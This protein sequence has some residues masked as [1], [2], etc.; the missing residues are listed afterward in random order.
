M[1]KAGVTAKNPTFPLSLV[2]WK[3][4]TKRKMKIKGKVK[5][6]FFTDRIGTKTLPRKKNLEP[7]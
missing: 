1:A 5:H 7:P 4:K 3:K 2:R 6:S